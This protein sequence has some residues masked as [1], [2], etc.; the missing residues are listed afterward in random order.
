MK[1]RFNKKIALALLAGLI[2]ISLIPMTANAC[3]RGGGGQ[4]GGCAMKGGQNGKHFAGALGVWKNTQA[5]KDLGLSDD[6]VNK[7][8]EADF[9]AREQYQAL[10]AEMDGLRLKMDHAF[11]AEKV[12]DDAVRK[13]SKQISAVKGKMIEQ[14]TETRLILQNLLTPEQLDTLNSRLGG[15]GQGFGQGKGMKKNCMMNGQGGGENGMGM[16]KG[17]RRR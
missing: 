12:N 2:I 17:Q 3:R 10:R 6:Q 7:L 1:T 8:K 16:K 15:R 14:R 13:L 11:A 9:A 4:G 5:V